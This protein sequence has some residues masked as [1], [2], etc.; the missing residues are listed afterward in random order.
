MVLYKSVGMLS[1]YFVYVCTFQTTPLIAASQNNH[2]RI[3]KYLLKYNADVTH[4]YYRSGLNCL[5][6]A[7]L[8][9][10]R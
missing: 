9:G 2:V 3:V 4:E 5:G 7:I 6:E 1:L 8:K 10:H